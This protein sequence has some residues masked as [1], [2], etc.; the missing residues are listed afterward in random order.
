VF[1]EPLMLVVPVDHPLAVRAE[2]CFSGF[3]EELFVMYPDG[4]DLSLLL[5]RMFRE[6]GEGTGFRG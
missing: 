4:C 3:R 5:E 6:R 2:V 1:T